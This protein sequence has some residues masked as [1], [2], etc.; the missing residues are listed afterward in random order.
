MGMAPQA[1]VT[2]LLC[3]SA[4]WKPA[5]ERVMSPHTLRLLAQRLCSCSRATWHRGQLHQQS[6]RERLQGMPVWL[7]ASSLVWRADW[8]PPCDLFLHGIVAPPRSKVSVMGCMCRNCL[9]GLRICEHGVHG[10]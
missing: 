5:W 1:N 9:V 6:R 3:C 7:S 8:F 2:H 10:T 4:S